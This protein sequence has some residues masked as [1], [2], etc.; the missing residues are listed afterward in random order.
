MTGVHYSEALNYPIEMPDGSMV[1]PGSTLKK[2]ND[3]WN[4]RWS[5]TKVEWGKTNG[6][7]LAPKEEKV[8][9]VDFKNK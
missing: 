1:Y 7:P 9:V 6:F 4:Y 8:K 5:K 3:N 2:N